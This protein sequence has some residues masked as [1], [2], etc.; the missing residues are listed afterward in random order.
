VITS[1]RLDL[2]FH[3]QRL[4]SHWIT[5]E[6]SVQVPD[7]N[8]PRRRGGHTTTVTIGGE[9]FRLTADG[10]EDGTLAEIAIGWGKHGTGTAGLMDAYATAITAGLEH[11][12]PLADL[13]RPGLGLRFVPNGNTDDPEIPRVRSVA[14]YLSRRLAVD[15][16]PWPERAA[17][18]VLTLGERVAR[19]APRVGADD[20]VVAPV[21]ASTIPPLAA[22]RN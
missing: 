22:G 7:W 16:L 20:A 2:I 19:A 12:V 17:L 11:G 21:S 9:Q 14:D 18:G 6:R 8:M 1:P 15:W 3:V 5:K 10:R 13:L 4:I